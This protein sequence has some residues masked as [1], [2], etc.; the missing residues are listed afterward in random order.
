[1]CVCVRACV[2]VCVCVCVCAC[3]HVPLHNHLPDT[4]HLARING[5][6]VV[7]DVVALGA[8]GAAV[9]VELR[10]EQKK[11]GGQDKHNR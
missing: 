1:M 6:G 7:E 5:P 8:S 2:R 4:R 10:G 9:L 3:H 11:R